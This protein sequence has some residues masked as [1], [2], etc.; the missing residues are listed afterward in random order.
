MMNV[1][2]AFYMI[3][4]FNIIKDILSACYSGQA[5]FFQINLLFSLFS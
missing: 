3:F 1:S 2:I 5:L 4:F